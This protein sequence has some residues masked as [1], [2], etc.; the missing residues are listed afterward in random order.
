M[1]IL[2]FYQYFTTP[3]GSWGTRAY[4]F[5]RRWVSEGDSV[6]IVTS[7]YDKSDLKPKS[8]IARFDVEGIDVRVVNV[9]L[10][11]KHGKARRILTF[12]AYALIACW[13]ALTA[14]ADVVLVSSGPITVGLPGLVAR[15]LRRRPLVFEVRDLWPEGAVQLGVLRNRMVIRLS[16]WFERCCYR[17]AYCVVALSPGQADWIRKRN[18]IQ[19]LEVVTNASDIDLAE[20]TRE[21][22][23]IPK[24]AE[25]NCLA[26]YAGTLGLIDDCGQILD[27]AALLQH[28][29]AHDIQ[30]V[31][32]GDGGERAALEERARVM[33]LKN[34]RFLGLLSR[35]ASMAWLHSATCALFVTKNVP[36]LSTASPN[37]LFD[38][39]AAGIP[40]IQTTEGWIRDLIEEEQCGLNVAPDDPQALVDAITTLMRDDCVRKRLAEN[41][42]R[43]GRE[44]YDRDRL[45]ARMNSI[46]TAA[47]SRA[48]IPM[49]EEVTP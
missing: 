12:G 9:R 49:H 13:Y 16:R 27:A 32:I 10:S 45:A 29:G 2:Y 23:V 8:L 5:A 26:I 31:L 30:F 11:N 25:G 6:T 42:A 24:W 48:E 22:A 39:F 1:R 36:F 17:A 35:E 34:V 38:A 21:H 41:A 33:K 46:L 14:R 18:R 15:Y 43:L 47:A 3:K 28:D 19:R 7:V 40:V 44:R 20:R 4:E 37:K